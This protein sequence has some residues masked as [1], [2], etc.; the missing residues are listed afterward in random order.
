MAWMGQSELVA[1]VSAGWMACEDKMLFGYIL[2][3]L[4][5]MVTPQLA[6]Y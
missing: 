2:V 6:I 1:S 3:L 5:T 4:L